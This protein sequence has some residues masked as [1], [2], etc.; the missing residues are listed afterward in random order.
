MSL[1]SDV[2]EASYE[3]SSRDHWLVE[4]AQIAEDTG[5]AIYGNVQ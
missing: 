2:L 1:S 3:D 4:S 5:R